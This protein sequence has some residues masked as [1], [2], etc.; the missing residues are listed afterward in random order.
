M[1]RN[2][3]TIRFA[4]IKATTP[5]KLIPSLQ[6]I[7]TAK[8]L[9]TEQTNELMA[10]NGPTIGSH[11]LPSNGWSPRNGDCEN[12]FWNQE[13]CRNRERPVV[14]QQSDHFPIRNN[15]LDGSRESKS[16]NKGAKGSHP[17]ANAIF[18]GCIKALIITLT[19][20]PFN[21]I[22]FDRDRSRAAARLLD[23]VDHRNVYC[24]ASATRRR[25]TIARA[26]TCRRACCGH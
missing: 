16:E 9:P 23:R 19:S 12:V 18:K 6:K 21:N 11:S 3:G 4:K 1:S 14:A 10:T 7:A 15:A 26:S 22:H 13:N 20:R 2:G 17:I 8:T 5:P 24:M 25:T